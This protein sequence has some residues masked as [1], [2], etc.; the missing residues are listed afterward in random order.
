MGVGNEVAAATA[1][2]QEIFTR[3]PS[4]AQAVRS[5]TARLTGTGW[6]T[7]VTMGS[8]TIIADQPSG[9]GDDSGPTPGDLVRGGLAA[10]LAQQ[11]AMHA[12]RFAV[13]LAG[14][15]VAVEADLDAR[16]TFGIETGAPPGFGAVRF[17]TTLVSDAPPEQV[18]ALA[19]YVEAHN[20]SVE[21]LRRAV[22]VT[23]DLVLRTAASQTAATP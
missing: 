2:A 13:A 20:P 9:L 11:Y 14:I 6:Q 22:P 21:E 10:C 5:A 8:H 3:R 1:R 19:A 12:A 17:T 16:P 18:R 7:E 15:E 23:G 4:A